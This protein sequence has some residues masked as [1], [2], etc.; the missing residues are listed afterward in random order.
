MKIY[1]S[2]TSIFQKQQHLLKTLKSILKQSLLP[3]KCFIYLSE[4]PYLLDKGFKDRK[5]NEELADFININ[6][7]FEI[8]WCKNIGPYRKLLY[9]LREKW[10]EDC[11]ILTMDDDILYHH[12]LIQ[13]YINDYNKYKCCI[14]YRGCTHDFKNRDF[15]DFNYNNKKTTKLKDLF[16]FAN[17]GVGTITHPTFFHKTDKLIFNLDLINDLCKTTD[18]VWYYFCRIAN[19]IDTVIINKPQ[20]ILFNFHNFNEISLFMNFNNKNNTNTEA[21]KKTAKKFIELN[22]M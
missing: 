17:S 5:L 3:D 9:L 6:K 4:E 15:S 1:L 10:N 12:N 13:D 20:Y 16:N 2:L 21:F 19:N 7:L 11:L 22:L 8:K 14:S 18:D